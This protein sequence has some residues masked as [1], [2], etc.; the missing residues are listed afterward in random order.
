[1][2]ATELIFKDSL[3]GLLR[4]K[5]K[6]YDAHNAT[7]VPGLDV[8]IE[9]VR[10]QPN[11]CC[12][13]VSQHDAAKPVHSDDDLEIE[14]H[15]RTWVAAQTSKTLLKID[16]AKA[17]K[18]VSADE[19]KHLDNRLAVLKYIHRLIEQEGKTNGL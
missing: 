15:A 14:T 6:F 2:E 17:R 9:L 5:A 4:D 7:L 10:S 8:A 16:K 1:M 11:V 12:C 3:L 13:A 19:L 18:G